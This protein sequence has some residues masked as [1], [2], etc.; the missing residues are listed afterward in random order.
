[1][2]EK[3]KIKIR[4]EILSHDRLTEVL[5]YDPIT[6]IFTWKKQMMGRIKI[7]QRAGTI[8]ANGHRQIRLDRL[9][10]MS[11]R[12]AWFYVHGVWPENEI[13]HRDL[14]KD[15]N[16]IVNL[17]EATHVENCNNRRASPKTNKSGYKGVSLLRGRWHAQIKQKGKCY[18]LGYFDDPAEAHAVYVAAS[19]RLHGDFGRTA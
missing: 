14:V 5:H 6:G 7:G 11:H 13:D 4:Q 17:R 8:N 16:A 19:K 3:E 12:L 2:D 18:H 10:W 15:N 9:T 1:M